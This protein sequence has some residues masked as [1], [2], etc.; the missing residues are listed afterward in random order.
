MLPRG[1]GPTPLLRSVLLGLAL[2]ELSSLGCAG[3]AH[4]EATKGY[5]VAKS[6]TYAWATEDLVMIG[7]GE[8]QPQVRTEANERRLRAAIDASLTEH[9]Y[10]KAAPADADLIVAFSVGTRVRYRLEGGENSYIASLQPG[11]KQTKAALHIYLLHRGDQ[12]E[13]W[14][15]WTSK[16]L[17]RGDDP[18][19][20]V[21]EAVGQIMAE[22]PARKR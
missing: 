14:H 5:D 4:H 7:V 9:G 2:L 3:K 1:M 22:L 19:T 13:A 16:W 15:G 8:P 17:T 20:V 12:I 21:R 6:A 11:E 10:A 18:D